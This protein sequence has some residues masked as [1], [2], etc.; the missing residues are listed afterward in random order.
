MKAKAQGALLM[1]L[2]YIFLSLK[3]LGVA[4]PGPLGVRPCP[5]V[6]HEGGIWFRGGGLPENVLVDVKFPHS[7]SHIA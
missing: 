7:I 4:T 5:V 1:N 6:E 3:L 2:C